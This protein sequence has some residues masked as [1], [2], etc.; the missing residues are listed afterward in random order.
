MIRVIT[1]A[2]LLLTFSQIAFATHNRAGE[3]TYEQVGPLTIRATITTY[4]K[5]SSTG[6]DRDTLDLFW[7]DG[8][9]TAIARSNGDGEAIPGFDLKINYYIAEHTFPSRSTYTMYFIDPNRVGGILNLNFPSSVDIRFYVETTFTLLSDQFQGLNNSAILLNP[10]IDF[11]CVGQR[12]IHNPNAYD[13]DGDS[14]SYEL[15]V[16]LQDVDTPVP[17]YLFPDNIDAGPENTITFNKE[18]GDFIWNS[19]MMSGEYSIAIRVN[20]YRNGE[21]INS[22]VRDMQI[23][24]D[25]CMNEPPVIEAQEEYCVIAGETLEIPI[26][27][28]DNDE[29]QLVSVTATGGIFQNE[30]ANI[31]WDNSGEFKEPEVLDTLIWKTDCNDISEQS[32]QL[33][34]RAVD[35]GLSN[36][37]G[38]T[39]LKTILIKVVGPYPEDLLIDKNDGAFDLSWQKPYDCEV[40]EDN[41]FQGFSV[42]RKI[43]SNSFEID[44]CEN[45]LDG[46][47]YEIIEYLTMEEANGRY[48]Y[49]DINIEPN[50]VYC[51]RVLGNFGLN[52]SAGYVYNL[53]ES[54]P[55]MEI[56]ETSSRD[57]PL[58]TNVDV[59]TTE[60]NDGH[61]NVTWIKPDPEDLDTLEN[62]GPYIY[63]LQRS[64]DG[65]TFENIPDAQYTNLNFSDSLTREYIDTGLNT[66]G[67]SYFYQM[68]ISTNEELGVSPK[69]ESVFLNLQSTDRRNNLSWDEDTPWL[70]FSY[71]I[72]EIEAGA[73]NLV[74]LSTQSDQQFS[75]QGLVND[76]EY[77]YLVES[78]GSYGLANTPDTIINRSQIICGSPIDTVAVCPPT[79]SVENDCE[80]RNSNSTIDELINGLAWNNPSV[81]CDDADDLAGYK[82]Y[83]AKNENLEFE[84]IQTVNDIEII[85]FDHIPEEGSTACY[86]VTTNDEIGNESGPS[87]II[88]ITNCPT[89]ELPNTF[90]PNSDGSNDVFIPRKNRFIDQVDFQVFNEW[91]NKVYETVDP[92]INWDGRDLNGKEVDDGTYYYNCILIEEDI[93]G[94]LQEKVIL[95]G[96]IEVLR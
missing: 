77:C 40:T 36:N 29:G 60:Q 90:T 47:G 78:F 45:G 5:A 6:A 72:Y 10:P 87:N 34:I 88:C 44:T 4:T 92:Q 66:Q 20:E 1:I 56:C 53:V 71:T 39:D 8:T 73:G 18:N 75:H 19:P 27:V 80:S 94:L 50:K 89:Y 9:S 2:I 55:S 32:Y 35:N 52:T 33:L 64:I 81:V 51:Y 91:G 31:I 83:Y 68:T 25:I 46:K 61:I 16:P 54:L 79:L 26:R 93:E 59:L 67:Q 38:L 58:L 42:W 70:N 28:N 41:Y 62:V 12:F 43:G 17:N 85:R 30:D 11:A 65:I 37:Q 21:L 13:P 57:V 82:I 95:N 23:F 3:I 63:Q 49:R 84:L 76:Q 48:T 74:E 86:Y 22:I 69:A 96:F 7:G 15:V 24:V 14:L